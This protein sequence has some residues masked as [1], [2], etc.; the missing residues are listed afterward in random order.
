MDTRPTPGTAPELVA[1]ERLDR[2]LQH[3][4]TVIL[5][6]DSSGLI[7]LV[8]AGDQNAELRAWVGQNLYDLT[9]ADVIAHEGVYATLNEGKETRRQFL[10]GGRVFRVT[11][12]PRFD[13]GAVNGLDAVAADVT[14][15]AR[16]RSA[17]DGVIRLITEITALTDPYTQAHEESVAEIAGAIAPRIGLSRTA[18]EGLRVAALLHDTGK[19]AI[20]LE[21]LSRPGKLQ[22]AEFDLIK[23]HVD[24]ARRMFATVTFPWTE[25]QAIYEHHERMDGSGYPLGLAGDEISLPGR[26][27]AVADVCDA[28]TSH[29]PYRPAR[30]RAELI[31]ELRRGRERRYD[32][33]VVDVALELIESGTLPFRK[34]LG[35]DRHGPVA[36]DAAA[37]AEAY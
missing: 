2:L 35:A 4:P 29:R 36:P 24:N 17:F 3:A 15:E 18:V 23:T 27:L 6:A 7:T 21:L 33:R 14:D 11:F 34:T 22:P 25:V 16:F 9:G 26:I 31:E 1:G 32:R 19:I 37:L 13:R 30:S 20:P 12:Y 5:S 10:W 8:L 28:M